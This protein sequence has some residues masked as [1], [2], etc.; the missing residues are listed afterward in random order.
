MSFIRINFFAILLNRGGIR[1]LG[2]DGCFVI[3]ICGICKAGI[4][5]GARDHN[6]CQKPAHYALPFT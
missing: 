4:A 5:D 2:L 6:E 1:F 3:G